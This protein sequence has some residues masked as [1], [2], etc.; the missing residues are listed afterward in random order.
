MTVKRI[1]PLESLAKSTRLQLTIHLS[2]AAAVAAIAAVLSEA[3]GGNGAV[4]LI[5]PT[6]SGAEA[7]VL[8][9]R[10]FALDGELALKLERIAGE[11]NVDLSAQEG[12]KLALVS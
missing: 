9:G 8:A 10:D 2:D 11:G 7:T 5:V 12:P 4:R 3:H 1:Q 6:A